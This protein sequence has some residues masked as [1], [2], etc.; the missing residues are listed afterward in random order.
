[1]K[2]KNLEAVRS[3]LPI[4][5]IV[6]LVCFLLIP[7]PS[8]AMLAFILGALMLVVGMGLFTL[9]TERAMTPIG[10]EVGQALTRSRNIKLILIAGFAVGAMVTISEPDLNVLAG[11]V[12]GVPNMVLILAVALGVGLF[13]MLALIRILFKIKMSLLLMISYGA[14][15]LLS[16]F[17]PG[18]FLAVAFDSGGVTTGP[19]TVPFILALGVG[20]SSIR[21][22]RDAEGDSFGLVALS[23]IGPILAVMLLSIFYHPGETESSTI[24][25]IEAGDSLLIFRT[26]L[27]ALPEYA[28]DVGIALLPIV[29]FFVVF[30]F[31]SLHLP[32]NRVIKICIGLLYT[33]VGLVLFLTGVNVGFMPVGNYIGKLLGQTSYKWILVPLGGLIGWF[34]VSAE[35][36]VHVLNDQVYTMTAGAVPKSAL[37]LSLSAGVAVSVALAMLRILTGLPIMYLLV[38]GYLIS[39]VLMFF[40]PPVFTSIA[41]DSGGVA[42]GPMTATFLLPLA[43]GACEAVGGNVGQDAFGVV[44]MVA[45]TPLIAIQILGVLYKIRQSKQTTVKPEPAEDEIIQL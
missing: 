41:F 31:A 26:F 14:V 38:P 2:E 44:A 13:L 8:N 43:M 29:L 24:Q 30:Q 17:V 36:A 3:V 28:A 12:S 27:Q 9:G 34:V 16:L 6:F 1:M 35:P 40:T 15:F 42:S 33:Y 37:R 18:D 11:Q 19:M 23:S 25:M 39:I 4:T 5:V 32:A 7:V 10:Q 45:M 22:D 21:S 20:V